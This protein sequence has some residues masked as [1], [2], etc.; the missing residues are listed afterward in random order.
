MNRDGARKS[1]WQEEIKSFS[2]DPDFEAVYDVVIVGGGITGVSTALKLKQEGKKCIIL[3]ASNI[4]FGTTG[5][6]TAHLNDFFDTTFSQAVSNFGLDNAKIFAKAGQDAI[7]LIK[8]NIQQFNIDCDF[9]HKSAYLFALDEKQDKQLKDIVEGASKVNH[10]MHF[11]REIPFPVPFVNGVLIPDQAQF[12]PVKYIK[13]LCEAFLN[14]GGEILEDCLCENHEEQE[15]FIIVTTS[16]GKIRVRNLVYATHIPPGKNVLSFVNAPYRSYAMAFSLKN[17]NYPAELGYDLVDPYHYYRTQTIGGETLLI[18]GG[19]DHKTGHAEDTGECF[20]KL[21]NYV[22]KYFEVDL[23]YF[24]WSSQYYEP[25]DGFPYIGKSPG[26]NGSVFVATGFR[27]NGMI[28]GTLSSQIITDLILGRENKYADLFNPSRIK[29][30]AGMAD[31]IK[32]TAAA[33]FDFIKDK[34]LKEKIESLGGITEGEAKVVKYEGNS[35]ALYKESNGKV[36]L[37]KSSCTHAH[38][39]VRWNSAEL[40]WDCPCHGSRFNVNGK[41]LTAPA[42]NGLQR[43]DSDENS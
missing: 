11:T 2:S 31:F 6:T 5:G 28:F 38:C 24:S 40:S 42:V 23:V 39:D 33:A 29:P 32:E 34:L 43:V 19:E 18:A 12:H 7:Q 26:S 13:A 8:N 14:L 16:K 4:G 36:H 9:E 37:L 20:S 3:E 21:E 15:D 35:Y 22:R 27:G 17:K 25:I 10:T 30:V 41:I 1:I